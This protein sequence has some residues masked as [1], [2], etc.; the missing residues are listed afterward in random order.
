[1]VAGAAAEGVSAA[2]VWLRWLIEARM[3]GVLVLCLCCLLLFS[4]VLMF[5]VVD[6]P[7]VCTI[8]VFET[9]CHGCPVL[10]SVVPL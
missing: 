6:Q 9:L 3:R 1:M 2:A 5:G 7:C 4:V 8:A 10:F